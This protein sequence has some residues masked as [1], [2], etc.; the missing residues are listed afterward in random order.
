M[1]SCTVS[2]TTLPSWGRTTACRPMPFLVRFDELTDW[3]TTMGLVRALQ[4]AQR[5][6]DDTI[7]Y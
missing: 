1:S 5:T 2:G 7:V 3:H 6:H 4:L